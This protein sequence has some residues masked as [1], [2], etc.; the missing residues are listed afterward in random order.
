[1]NYKKKNISVLVIVVF[2]IF[3][4]YCSGVDIKMVEGKNKDA[5]VRAE[6]INTSA[7]L[8]AGFRIEVINPSTDKDLVLVVRD[9]LSYLFDVRLINENG[10]NISP[11]RSA[12]PADK[13]GPNMPKTYRYETILPGANRFWFIPVPSQVRADLGK[14]TNNDNLKPTPNGE[15]MA[16]ILVAISYFIQGKEEKTIPKVPKFQSL[17]LTLP[18]IPIVVDSK[19]LGQNIEDMYWGESSGSKTNKQAQVSTT[20]NPSNNE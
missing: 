9:N 3:S 20:N 16:E 14:F 1:M 7:G 2:S 15:Y 10:V 6:C 13:R 18:R 17:Q 19:Q 4:G 12:I 5:V 8:T 11:L